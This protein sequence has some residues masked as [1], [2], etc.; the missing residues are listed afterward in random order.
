MPV[1]PS[2]P[3]PRNKTGQKI[4]LGLI[5]DKVYNVG[6]DLISSLDRDHKDRVKL[7]NI[8]PFYVSSYE[9]HHFVRFCS[10]DPKEPLSYVPVH[11]HVP[12]HQ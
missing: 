8:S 1:L 11:S 4:S 2:M 10:S 5:Y 6:L 9:P 3:T 12:C 7:I